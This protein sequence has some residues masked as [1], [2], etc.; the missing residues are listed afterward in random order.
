M[1]LRKDDEFKRIV[2]ITVLGVGGAGNNAVNRM[3]REKSFDG[4]EFI[5]VN[6]DMQ[7][8]SFSS[9]DV[10]IQ[11]GEK[12]TKGQGA[13][14]EPEVGRKATEESAEDI[15]K[16]LEGVDMLFITAGMGGGTGTGGAPV[17]A[18][19]AKDMGILTIG[20]V[21][22]PFSFEGRI[23]K[24]NADAGLEALREQ[25]DSLVV[26]PNDHIKRIE[27]DEKVGVKDAFAIADSVLMKAVASIS[28]LI[29]TTGFI[30]IDFADIK[31][32]M[33]DVGYAHMGIGRATGKNKLEEVADAVIHSPLLETSIRGA[34]KIILNTV[35]SADIGMEEVEIVANIIQDAAHEDV[36]LIFGIFIDE[37]LTDEIRVT[38]IATDFEK[39]EDKFEFPTENVQPEVQ[40]VI[41][42]VI[43]PDTAT[44]LTSQTPTVN[45]FDIKSTSN[46]EDAFDSIIDILKNKNK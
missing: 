10:K 7:A 18:K 39:N 13:G 31:R 38:I 30:N 34:K 14:A 26:I 45:D 24:R 44:P 46:A 19:I 15:A 27:L 41:Q 5:A 36:N 37:E 22:R 42:P 32:V 35:V 16:A 2:P 33:K 8:L 29:T 20:V 28:E 43:Q 11:M 3:V 1:S 9:A 21:S 25:V 12:L 4:I 23:R 40:P 6:T 17:I